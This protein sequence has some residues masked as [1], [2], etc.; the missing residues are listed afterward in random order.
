MIIIEKD[1]GREVVTAHGAK[2][3]ITEVFP[4]SCY[5]RIINAHKP[6]ENDRTWYDQVWSY[7]LYGTFHI[8]AGHDT[9]G[10]NVRFI[11]EQPQP[12]EVKQEAE[13]AMRFN[14]NKFGISL[15]P[16]DGIIELVRVYT[17]GA[18]KYKPNNWLKGMPWEECAA[19]LDRHWFK[20][21]CG[22]NVDPDTGCHH[23]AHVM[24]NAL[25]LL[26]YQLRGIGKDDRTKIN[27]DDDFNLVHNPLGIGLSPE[28]LEE[29][30]NK[31]KKQRGEE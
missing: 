25:T 21:R 30:Q 4:N 31:Y 22:H 20:W 26:V 23:L 12:E 8:I 15:L 17:V 3:V 10:M 7:D 13:R 2:G 29:L 18:F 28:K 14:S 19:S 24:W 27:I 1:V 11:D 16:L 6:H 5:I 9:S